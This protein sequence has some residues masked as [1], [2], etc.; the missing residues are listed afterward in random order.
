MFA[1]EGAESV[2]ERSTFF[3]DSLKRL[4]SGAESGFR[5]CSGAK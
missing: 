4:Y 5:C 2:G 1:I 3:T